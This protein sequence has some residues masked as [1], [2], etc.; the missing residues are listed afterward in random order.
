MVD[1]SNNDPLK[2]L[3]EHNDRLTVLLSD[4]GRRELDRLVLLETL[5]MARLSNA[6]SHLRSGSFGKLAERSSI[7]PDEFAGLLTTEAE[8]EIKQ[9]DED[10]EDGFFGKVW[11]KCKSV[12][13]DKAK[14]WAKGWVGGGN[15]EDGDE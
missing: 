1:E 11:D 8:N 15:G 14:G 7:P 10:E 13:N 5:L 3:R 4:E 12:A 9:A 6:T 2:L